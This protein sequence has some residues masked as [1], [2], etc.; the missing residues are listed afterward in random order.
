MPELSSHQKVTDFPSFSQSSSVWL[1]PTSWLGSPR[2]CSKSFHSM[3]CTLV[4][5]YQGHQGFHGQS[6]TWFPQRCQDDATWSP[7]CPERLPYLEMNQ[8]TEFGKINMLQNNKIYVDTIK[9]HILR[10]FLFLWTD[11][12]RLKNMFEMNKSLQYQNVNPFLVVGKCLH[13]SQMAIQYNSIY[14]YW[15]FDW[16]TE[17]VSHSTYAEITE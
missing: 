14:L 16:E 2:S 4:C 12:F 15:I 7:E 9:Y 8:W 13:A 10:I 1:S 6:S 3:F 17:E 11:Q 5:S